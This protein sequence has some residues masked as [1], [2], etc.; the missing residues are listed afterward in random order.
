M[1]KLAGAGLTVVV[2]L[3]LSGLLVVV[4]FPGAIPLVLVGNRGTPS[5]TPV[6]S[7]TFSPSPLPSPSPSPSPTPVVRTAAL[8]ALTTD[9]N[10]IA[11]AAGAKAS[12]SLIELGGVAPLAMLSIK[13]D[14]SWPAD[15]T[16]KLPLLMADA[17]RIA[18]G[19]WKASDRICFQDEEHEDGWF[20]DYE[21]GSCFTRQALAERA[22]IYSDNTAGHMLATNL[23][24]GTV[25]NDYARQRG[26]KT[27]A[28]FAPNETTASDLAALMATEA[29]GRAGGASAQRWLYP[30]LTHS[31]F[32]EGLPAGVPNGVTV[33]HKIGDVD[34]TVNDV[35]LISGQGKKYVLAVMTIGLGGEAAW[36]L[37]A[38]ISQA[39]W[40]YESS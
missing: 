16:Y 4:V 1:L 14:T 13:G 39:V 7:V 3:L 23:G 30:L 12:V 24:G 34:Q 6:A 27:S 10:K 20:D 5:H 2:L 32:E 18:S 29:T 8:A 33:T 25:L 15:S 35:G 28:F 17:E 21:D 26:A 31:E 11:A 22:G 9:L 36:R 40:Q 37:V 19:S 38:A